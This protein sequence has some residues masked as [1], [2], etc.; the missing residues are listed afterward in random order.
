MKKKMGEEIKRLSQELMHSEK[1]I[2]DKN[3]KIY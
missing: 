2:M 3:Q 1:E